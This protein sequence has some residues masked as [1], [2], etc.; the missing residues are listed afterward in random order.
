MEIFYETDPIRPWGG[1]STAS[2]LPRQCR[3]LVKTCTR[4]KN[5]KPA[6]DSVRGSWHQLKRV[7]VTARV[8]MTTTTTGLTAVGRL[9]C[10]YSFFLR[11][12]ISLTR[13][14]LDRYAKGTVEL[15]HALANSEDSI[16]VEL[17]PRVSR[18]TPLRSAR[19]TTVANQPHSPKIPAPPQ[20]PALRPH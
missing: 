12:L 5:K 1:P 20:N 15:S 10:S 11:S 4:T 6:E 8:S 14:Q 7:L 9:H 19:L 18:P 17:N 13:R 16:T 2:S 3:L